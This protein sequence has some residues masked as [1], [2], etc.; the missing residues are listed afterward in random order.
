MN[1]LKIM[2]K[3]NPKKYGIQEN[4]RKTFNWEGYTEGRGE[5]KFE[6]L[7]EDELEDWAGE[8]RFKIEKNKKGIYLR[9]KSGHRIKWK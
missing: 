8:W 7:T 4:T 5:Y 2:G 3:N 6:D 9:G 1:G